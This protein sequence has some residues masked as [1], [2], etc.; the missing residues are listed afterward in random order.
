MF[1]GLF[2][3]QAHYGYGD[4]ALAL[5]WSAFGNLVGGLV[6]VTAT[7]LVRVPHRIVEE[8]AHSAQPGIPAVREIGT[9]A[10]D[11]MDNAA[12]LG[13]PRWSWPQRERSTYAGAR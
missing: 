9:Y 4:W 5:A 13:S 11:S 7:R 10:K 2:G 8:R 3:G 12:V 1:A 6:L